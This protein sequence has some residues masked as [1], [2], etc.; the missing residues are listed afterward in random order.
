MKLINPFFREA[1]F[2]MQDRSVMIALVLV[3]CLSALSVV[4]GL[5]EV[6]SQELEIEQLIDSDGQDRLSELSRQESWGGAAYYSFH[7]TYDPPTPFAFVAMGQRDARPWKHRIRMLALEGQIYERDVNNPVVALI[8]R[9]DFSFFSAFVLPLI[10]IVILHDIRSSER[11]ERRFHLLLATVGT[12]KRLWI[13]RTSVRALSLY[14]A[15]IIPLIA[16]SIINSVSVDV[17]FKACF[18]LA[19]YFVFW[20][21]ISSWFA[22]WNKSSSV[23]LASLIGFWS[24]VAVIVPTAGR[25]AIDE[26]VTVPAGSDILMLQRETVNDAWDKPKKETMR[27]F[28]EHYPEWS[29]FSEIKNPF[30]WKWYYA[31]QQ[32]GDQ[33]AEKLSQAYREGRLERD[34][35]AGHMALFAPPALLERSLQY[36]ANTDTRSSL[37][38][39]E[40]VREFHA[41][42][43]QFYYPKLFQEQ[44]FDSDQLTKLP[45]FLSEQN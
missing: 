40:Q 43:R 35:L 12:A 17:I 28:L 30:E 6:K 38:Y 45:V 18:F 3:F 37:A 19:L 15:V 29:E 20:T 16:G 10:L 5:L 41:Q 26:F 4:G 1:A 25:M 44:P 8:G 23:I 21:V 34:R 42:L 24:L 33:T 32:V 36:L 22:S 27:A 9:F 39:E 7:L 14:I 11:R 31:F 13:T 2:M